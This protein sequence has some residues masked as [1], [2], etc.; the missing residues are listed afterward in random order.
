MFSEVKKYHAYARECLALAERATSADIR[1]RLIQLSHVWL[2]AA[3]REEKIVQDGR[4][5][6][7]APKVA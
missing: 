6:A 7:N 5:N 3:L 1:E 4:S 2:E